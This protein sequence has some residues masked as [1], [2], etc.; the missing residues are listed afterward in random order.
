M[1][2]EMRDGDS[3]CF[4]SNFIGVAII[5]DTCKFILL[6]N[7]YNFWLGT[8]NVWSTC[9]PLCLTILY[10]LLIPHYNPQNQS[11]KE[12]QRACY[13]SSYPSI[14]SLLPQVQILQQDSSVVG[15]KNG[16]VNVSKAESWTCTLSVYKT[17]GDVLFSLRP[18][19]ALFYFPYFKVGK[20]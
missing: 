20:W 16:Q 4:W 5:S 6:L 3:K 7:L 2:W 18:R 17:S 19:G 13:I 15:G 11:R 9:A 8:R 14:S 12:E 10:L 1:T